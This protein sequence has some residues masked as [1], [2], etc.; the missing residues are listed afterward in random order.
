M[1]GQFGT[2]TETQSGRETHQALGVFENVTE[3]STVKLKSCVLAFLPVSYY[4]YD[5]LSLQDPSS[6]ATWS[7]GFKGRTT[8][9]K[10][11]ENDL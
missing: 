3:W 5:K 11:S 4:V 6:S 1:K 10:C 8:L 2:V 7:T 9:Q